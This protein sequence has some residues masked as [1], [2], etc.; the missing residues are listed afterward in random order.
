MKV[1]V[2][3]THKGWMGLCPVY[4]ADPYGPNPRVDARHAWLEWLHDLSLGIFRFLMQIRLRQD[5][6]YEPLWPLVLTGELNPPKVV[7]YDVDPS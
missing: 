5:P 3:Y 6:N 7:T 4:L 1:T 2:S